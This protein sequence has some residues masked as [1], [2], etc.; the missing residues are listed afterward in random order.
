MKINN[1]FTVLA[2]SGL[3]LTTACNNSE[4]YI[5][6]KDENG[7]LIAQKIPAN[8]VV[9]EVEEK[10]PTIAEFI[11]VDKGFSTFTNALKATELYHTLDEE[12]IYTIFAPINSAFE[13]LPKGLQEKQLKPEDKEQLIDILKYHIIPSKITKQDIIV[14]INDGRGSI[15]LRTLGGNLLTASLKGGSIFLIDEMGNG[16]RLITTDVEASNGFINTIDNVM[17]PKK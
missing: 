17:M 12:G 11:S 4:K 13:S 3:L 7:K 6:T 1:V 8:G 10:V 5:V 14:A 15:P 16:G 9:E 2:L